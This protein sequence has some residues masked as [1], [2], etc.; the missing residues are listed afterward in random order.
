MEIS[1][2]RLFSCRNAGAK[3]LKSPSGESIGNILTEIW[4]EYGWHASTN[5]DAVS[6]LILNTYGMGK[7]GKV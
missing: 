6:A 7:V 2:R 3:K 5:S 4:R 1:W